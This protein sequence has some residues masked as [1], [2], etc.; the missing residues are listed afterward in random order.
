MRG[1]EIAVPPMAN[2][3]VVLVDVQRADALLAG[4]VGVENGDL[5]DKAASAALLW[6]RLQAESRRRA[7]RPAQPA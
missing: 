6:P 7:W 4:G 3:G 2:L 1:V 5:G